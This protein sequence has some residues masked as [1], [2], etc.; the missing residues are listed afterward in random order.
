MIDLDKDKPRKDEPV[1]VMGQW[2]PRRSW[3]PDDRRI[4]YV[5]VIWAAVV[6]VII[7]VLTERGRGPR[8]SNV[9][10]HRLGVC[11]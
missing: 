8:A 6:L 11:C 10:R 5:A 3:R 7:T 2:P 4:T 1:T 9:W